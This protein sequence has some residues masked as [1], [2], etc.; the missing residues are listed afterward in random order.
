MKIEGMTRLRNE[1]N[2]KT[3]ENEVMLS[4][5]KEQKT[6]FDY[7]NQNYDQQLKHLTQG[8]DTL[9]SDV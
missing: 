6:L 3:K 9:K 7:F 1:L 8:I 2:S 4:H 5:K